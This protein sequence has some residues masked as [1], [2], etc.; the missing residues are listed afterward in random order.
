MSKHNQVFKGSV[1][2]FTKRDQKLLDVLLLES[3]RGS[4]LAAAAVIN[5]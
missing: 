5:V 2:D 1:N 4:V 3:E